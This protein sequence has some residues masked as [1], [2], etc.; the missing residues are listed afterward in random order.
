MALTDTLL[1]VIALVRQTL[2]A[3]AA[4]TFL[5]PRPLPAATLPADAAITTGAAAG[6]L[7]AAPR[8]LPVVARPAPGGGSPFAPQRLGESSVT[9]ID[10]PPV[11]APLPSSPSPSAPGVAPGT[12]SEGA[13][14][15]RAL[16]EALDEE[17][18]TA[19]HEAHALHVV[20]SDFDS[21][22]FAVLAWADEVLISSDWAGAP[23]W[24]RQL[25]QRRH[26]NTTTAGVAFYTRLDDLRDDQ[27]AVREVY[28][29]CL[30]LG[31]RGRYAQE[32]DTRQ[33]DER[34]RRTLQQVLDAGGV[35]AATGTVLFPQAYVTEDSARAAQ[36]G[37]EPAA[38]R[39]RG[40]LRRQT[41]I[42]FGLPLLILVVLYGTYHAIIVQM[43]NALLPLIQ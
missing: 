1:P 35:P 18:D 6:A 39:V 9:E 5:R 14:R 17:I 43:V 19:R 29:L 40:R 8:P 30:A 42:A 24:Q 28:A 34:R 7:P 10:A 31:F 12:P 32:R 2:D 27:T 16:A 38:R 25:L 23:H 37:I 4:P 21:A 41:L 22:L 11:P 36:T 3:S 33:L 13:A 20:P 26:F 15:A